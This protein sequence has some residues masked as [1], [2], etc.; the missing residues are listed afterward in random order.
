MHCANLSIRKTKLWCNT[1]F[2]QKYYY[3]IRRK[4]VDLEACKEFEGVH[5][6]NSELKGTNG[7]AAITKEETCTAINNVKNN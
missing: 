4:T 1:G 5:Q 2:R 6:T 7:Y 3:Q